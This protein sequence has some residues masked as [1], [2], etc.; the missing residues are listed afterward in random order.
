MKSAEL[1]EIL[2]AGLAEL[3][4]RPRVLAEDDDGKPIEEEPRRISVRASSLPKGVGVRPET[5]PDPS[6]TTSK[7]ARLYVFTR[8]Q[9]KTARAALR[10]SNRK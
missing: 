3:E 6:E 5:I 4:R 8:K 7:N 2:E 1:L 10:K 9:A